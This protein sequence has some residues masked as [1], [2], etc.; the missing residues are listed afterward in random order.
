[1]SLL[2]DHKTNARHLPLVQHLA[3]AVLLHLLIQALCPIL[4]HL[5][6]LAQLLLYQLMIDNGIAVNQLMTFRAEA[7]EIVWIIS[8]VHRGGH[9]V[10]QLHAVIIYFTSAIFTFAPPRFHITCALSLS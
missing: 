5:W 1:M 8:A 9:N 10:M 4:A 2:N 3:L 6:M 7:H